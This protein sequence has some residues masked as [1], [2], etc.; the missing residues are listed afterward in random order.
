VNIKCDFA[1]LSHIS[2]SDQWQMPYYWFAFIGKSYVMI[3]WWSA[4][5]GTTPFNLNDAHWQSTII[6]NVLSTHKSYQ[7]LLSEESSTV[8]HNYEPYFGD[9][10]PWFD[11]SVETHSTVTTMTKVSIFHISTTPWQIHDRG[12]RWKGRV[13][14]HVFFLCHILNKF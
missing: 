1:I 12:C 8:E 14:N 10:A 13:H 9:L 2:A 11:P 4:E 5:S 7:C 6:V 3:I